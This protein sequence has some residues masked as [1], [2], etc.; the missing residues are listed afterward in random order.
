MMR[1]LKIYKEL[2]ISMN[3]KNKSKSKNKLKKINKDYNQL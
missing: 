3:N 1:L 2:M